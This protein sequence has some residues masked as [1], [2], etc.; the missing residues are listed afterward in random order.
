M[1]EDASCSSSTTAVGPV[2]KQGLEL[3]FVEKHL[4]APYEGEWQKHHSLAR[5]KY[6]LNCL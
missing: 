2:T 6:L 3:A 4:T 1:T 5:G